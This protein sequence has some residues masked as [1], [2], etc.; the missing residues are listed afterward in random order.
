MSYADDY[1]GAVPYGNYSTADYWWM[2]K[3]GPY[4]RKS[5]WA[6]GS[7]VN[8]NTYIYSNNHGN[9]ILFC[10]NS[11]R[12]VRPDVRLYLLDVF[13][14]PLLHTGRGR[15]DFNDETDEQ[16]TPGRRWL[17]L[18]CT[19]QRHAVHDVPTLVCIFAAGQ[20]HHYRHLELADVHCRSSWRSQFRVLRR[21][22]EVVP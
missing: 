9:S 2:A 10:P 11:I 5:A 19:C 17:A 1:N 21:P 4:I 12:A 8:S 18:W 3:V 22:C 14:K 7:Q 15:E 6:V 16:E 13:R 20:Q